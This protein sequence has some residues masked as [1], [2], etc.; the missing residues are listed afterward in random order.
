M[1][2]TIGAN[3]LRERRGG[4]GR[5]RCETHCV[6]DNPF[7]LHLRRVY[8]GDHNSQGRLRG[9]NKSMG[10]FWRYGLLEFDRRQ[11][12]QSSLVAQDGNETPVQ[13]GYSNT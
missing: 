6:I 11:N 4:E 9:K 7:R 2:G 8:E 10:M 1:D 13:R 3:E 5:A 12:D